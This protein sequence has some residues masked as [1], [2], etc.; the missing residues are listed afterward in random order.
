MRLLYR[1]PSQHRKTLLELSESK[2][3]LIEKSQIKELFQK[4]RNT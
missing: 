3:I 4:S 2:L 1:V